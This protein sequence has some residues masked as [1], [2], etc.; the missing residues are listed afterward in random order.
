MLLTFKINFTKIQEY[1]FMDDFRKK[2]R[3]HVLK[4]CVFDLFK[5]IL[6]KTIINLK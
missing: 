4:N 5:Y 6:I 3:I 2:I 1:I